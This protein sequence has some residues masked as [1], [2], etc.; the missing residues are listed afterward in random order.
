MDPTLLQNIP[1]EFKEIYRRHFKTIQTRVT[2]GRIKY[3][4]HFL[5][6]EQYSSQLVER[7]LSV[8]RQEHENGCKLN[9]AFGYILQNIETGEL[10]FFHPSNNTMLF[11]IPKLIK[12]Q[13]DY[14]QLLD[15]LEKQDVVE[16]SN[17]QRPSTKWIMVKIVCMRYDVYKVNSG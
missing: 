16:Y 5:M 17:T 3:I 7:Y 6:T 13:E 8:I 4:Y 15:D 12:S 14:T 10:K 11:E 9:A 1:D 2:R